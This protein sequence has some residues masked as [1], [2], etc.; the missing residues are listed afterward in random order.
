M[1]LYSNNSYNICLS[2]IYLICEYSFYSLSKS[3]LAYEYSSKNIDTFD[4]KNKL[5]SFV[6]YLSYMA[7][8]YICVLSL[9]TIFN[10]I[11]IKKFIKN[12][13]L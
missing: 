6:I 10:R 11:A 8:F 2:L 13:N 7:I 5:A 3:V 12:K 9:F 1:L 4:D